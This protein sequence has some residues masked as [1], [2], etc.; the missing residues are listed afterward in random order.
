MI[1]NYYEANR[2]AL[3]WGPSNYSLVIKLIKY[4]FVNFWNIFSSADQW[5]KYLPEFDTEQ[6][7]LRLFDQQYWIH[8][9]HRKMVLTS[10]AK[11]IPIFNVKLQI[12]NYWYCKKT[13][14]SSE[15]LIIMIDA[16]ACSHL[17]LET[18]ILL[19]VLKNERWFS[20]LSIY[21]MIKY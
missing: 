16:K 7:R 6:H 12:I 19:Q 18:F 2:W 21:K 5:G 14:T 4:W 11:R 9:T 10:K 3:T 8:Y 1:K 13:V 20:N 15:F 17:F